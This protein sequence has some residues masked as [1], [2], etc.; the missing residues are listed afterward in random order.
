MFRVTVWAALAWATAAQ[1]SSSNCSCYCCDTTVGL[2]DGSRNPDKVKLYTKT[3]T[4][5]LS[6]VGIHVVHAAAI[7]SKLGW[8]F[9]GACGGAGRSVRMHKANEEME[10]D[11]LFGNWS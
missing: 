5:G 6:S 11:F 3:T 10:F 7:A 4:D 2:S 9:M 8:K 1:A